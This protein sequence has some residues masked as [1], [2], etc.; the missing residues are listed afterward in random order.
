MGKAKVVEVGEAEAVDEA[1]RM[2]STNTERRRSERWLRHS[3][4]SRG[5]RTVERK[6]TKYQRRGSGAA[7]AWLL[8]KPVAGVFIRILRTS[9]LRVEVSKKGK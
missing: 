8:T 3:R 1:M 4:P 2:A 7:V 5:R 6:H 9:T